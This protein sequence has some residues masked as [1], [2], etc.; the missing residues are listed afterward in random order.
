LLK[1]FYEKHISLK[2]LSHHPTKI[3]F[4]LFQSRGCQK[5]EI[6]REDDAEEDGFVGTGMRCDVIC[7]DVILASA[8]DLT[9]QLASR[10]ASFLALDALEGDTEF[11]S[12]TCDCRATNEASKGSKG[13]R[14]RKSTSGADSNQDANKSHDKAFSDGH[15]ETHNGT[16]YEFDEDG[17]GDE[18]A[19]EGVLYDDDEDEEDGENGEEHFG[20]SVVEPE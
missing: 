1:P 15:N 6:V 8:I 3:L 20:E 16:S 4:E 12:R 9:A 11:L 18:L 17:D 5:F 7:H 2:T 19:V 10:R 14:R 13:S